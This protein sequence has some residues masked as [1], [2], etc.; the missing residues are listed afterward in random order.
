MM[1]RDTLQYA[2]FPSSSFFFF[3]L[4]KQLATGAK[5]GFSVPSFVQPEEKKNSGELL[6]LA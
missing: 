5:I 1:Y 3:F 2:F 4:N 6:L